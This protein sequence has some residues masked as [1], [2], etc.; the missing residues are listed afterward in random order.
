MHV[1]QCYITG[2]PRFTR[3]NAVLT[4]AID[5]RHGVKLSI[6]VL[7]RRGKRTPP[8]PT[9]LAVNKPSY[10]PRSEHGRGITRA[11]E[12]WRVPGGVLFRAIPW[13]GRDAYTVLFN[14]LKVDL[15]ARCQV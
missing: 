2:P 6:R 12:L 8:P 10:R 11:P 9:L 4:A 1:Q 7:D 5:P 14:I 3:H 13:L 15:A